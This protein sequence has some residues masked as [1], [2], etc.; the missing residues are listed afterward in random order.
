MYAI[1]IGK[2]IISSKKPQQ[3]IYYDSNQYIILDVRYW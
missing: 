3:T 1:I 2:Q